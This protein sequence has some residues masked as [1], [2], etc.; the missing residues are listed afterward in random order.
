MKIKK[1]KVVRV[2]AK[3][4]VTKLKQE[5]KTAREANKL[6]E[7]ETKDLS[8]IV[9]KLKKE[10]TS[11]EKAF[12]KEISQIKKQIISKEKELDKKD[13]KRQNAY[14]KLARKTTELKRN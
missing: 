10:L 7:K 11:K 12:K 8:S 13:K 14:V 5:V 6:L 3:K 2:L 4:D 9:K 1:A